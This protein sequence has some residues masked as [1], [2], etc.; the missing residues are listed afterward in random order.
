MSRFSEENRHYKFEF[1]RFAFIHLG[2]RPTGDKQ[3]IF[4]SILE[5]KDIFYVKAHSDRLVSF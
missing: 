4:F 3:N 5:L 2:T 1:H